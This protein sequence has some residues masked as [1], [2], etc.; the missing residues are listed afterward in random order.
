[1]GFKST[2]LKMKRKKQ[3]QQQQK[4]HLIRNKNFVCN[5]TKMIIK[6][7]KLQDSPPLRPF[8]ILITVSGKV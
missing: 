6:E 7:A 2:S 3:Q 8:H 4:K 1:M 5:R